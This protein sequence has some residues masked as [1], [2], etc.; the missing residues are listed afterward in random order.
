MGKKLQL[1]IV[2]LIEE[3]TSMSFVVGFIYLDLNGIRDGMTFQ[4][5][6]AQIPSLDL[7]SV[8]KIHNLRASSRTTKSFWL[9]N[10]EIKRSYNIEALSFF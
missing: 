1:M 6:F 9:E 7:N 10:N 2:E 3:L 8:W 4:T 5:F